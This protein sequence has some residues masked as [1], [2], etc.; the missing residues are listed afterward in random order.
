MAFAV[1]DEEKARTAIAPGRAGGSRLTFLR[2][3]PCI[4]VRP[5]TGRGG[6]PGAERP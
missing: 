3:S 2:L 1:D 5:A 4:G 6:R